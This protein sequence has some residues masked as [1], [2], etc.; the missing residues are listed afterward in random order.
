MKQTGTLNW[1]EW[2][3][4]WFFLLKWVLVK[5]KKDI[6]ANVT[7]NHLVYPQILGIHLFVDNSLVTFV[8]I[9]SPNS[10]FCDSQISPTLKVGFWIK[11]MNTCKKY[12]WNI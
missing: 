6:N 10:K 3:E 9:D 8:K 1:N 2:I 7:E 5:K 4:F 11:T 12:L